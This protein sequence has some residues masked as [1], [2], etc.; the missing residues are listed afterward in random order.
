MIPPKKIIIRNNKAG[1]KFILPESDF[2]K[3]TEIIFED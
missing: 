3:D 2:F 1:L